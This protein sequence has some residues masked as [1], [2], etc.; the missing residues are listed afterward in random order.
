MDALFEG[1]VPAWK[2]CRFLK[3]GDRRTGVDQRMRLSLK[4]GRFLSTQ[5]G[6][7]AMGNAGKKNTIETGMPGKRLVRELE[8]PASKRGERSEIEKE[9]SRFILIGKKGEDHTEG[10]RSHSVSQ[11]KINLNASVGGLPLLG[12]SRKVAGGGGRY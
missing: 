11:K 5:D 2:S 10:E 12:C 4:G 1:I 7:N 3:P 6:G 8:L 9:N